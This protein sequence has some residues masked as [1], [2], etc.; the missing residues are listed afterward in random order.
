MEKEKEALENKIT[1]LELKHEEDKETWNKEEKR[2]KEEN[3]QLGSQRDDLQKS[4]NQQLTTIAGLIENAETIERTKK[5]VVEKMMKQNEDLKAE[6]KCLMKLK[7]EE[8]SELGKLS[9][10]AKKSESNCKRLLK[11]KLDMY[12]NCKRRKYKGTKLIVP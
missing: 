9:E 5:E 8:K 4:N 6:N 1:Q 2:L 10:R 7:Y 11:E 12:I 3:I